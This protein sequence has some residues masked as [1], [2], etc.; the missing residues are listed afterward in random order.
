[1][2]LN[3]EKSISKNLSYIVHG[4][5]EHSVEFIS[6]G[7]FCSEAST[8]PIESWSTELACVLAKSISERYVAKPYGFR[9]LTHKVYPELRDD[10]GEKVKL[11]PKLLKTSGIYFLN[12]KVLKCDDIPE[13]SETHILRLNMWCNNWFLVCETRNSYRH[14]AQFTEEDFVVDQDGVVLYRGNDKEFVEYR[15]QCEAKKKAE[16][17]S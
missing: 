1:M 7:T 3:Q 8:K 2:S 16:Y 9:F 6:P 14:T 5:E 10:S 12:G 17:E 4:T 11:I 15:K 13:S